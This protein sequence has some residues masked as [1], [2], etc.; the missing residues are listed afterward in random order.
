[1]KPHEMSLTVTQFDKERRCL[2]SNDQ[3]MVAVLRN[4][5]SAEWEALLSAGPDMARALHSV[6]GSLTVNDGDA[7]QVRVSRAQ[8]DAIRAALTKAGVLP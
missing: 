8:W 3:R 4:Y 1:M 2:V 7:L 6:F 5:E